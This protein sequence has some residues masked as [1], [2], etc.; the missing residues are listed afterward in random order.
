M[1]NSTIEIFGIRHH[2]PGSARSLRRALE[3]FK[4]DMILVEGPPDADA[5][6]AQAAHH[7]MQP[8]VALLVYNPK[9]LEQASFF[10][11][12]EF[13]PEWQAIRYGQKSRVSV[14]FMD[15]PM[16]QAF[17]L[18]EPE[19]QLRLELTPLAKEDPEIDPFRKI[20]R[21]A[22]YT[23]PERWW[24][25]MVE[26]QSGADI[27]PAILDL[28]M[29]LR[30]DK[31]RPETRETLLREAFMRQ[32][33]RGALQEGYARIAVVCGAWHTP[34]LENWQTIKASADAALLK[35][36][37]KI[38][39]ETTW[40]PWSF[41]RLAAQN[42]YSAGV[43]APAWYRVL[44]GSVSGNPAPAEPS[45]SS[46]GHLYNP[47]VQWLTKVAHLLRESDMA[48]SPAHIIEAVRL[49]ETLAVLR[50]T[51]LPG[52]EELREAAVT[53]LCD[54]AEKPLELI[55]RQLVIG[56]VLGRVPDSLPV[57]PLKADFE[58]QV[59]SCRLEKN[60]QEK[61][62]E[63]D[64]RQDAHLRKS[65]LLHRLDLLGIQWGTVKDAVSG[66]QGG[67]HEHWQLKWLPDYEIRLIE[68]GTWGNTVED[69]AGRKAHR[70]VLESQE[71]AGLVRLL[72][73]LLKANL[74]AALPVLLQKLQQIT[75]LARDALLLADAVLPL[76]GVLRYGTARRLN[77]DAVEQLLEQIIPR[78]CIQLPAACSGVNGD[79]AEDILKK[80]LSVNRALGIL[81]VAEYETGWQNTLS[82]IGD[83]D[84]TAPLLSGLSTR[85]LF[86]KN[87]RTAALTGDRMRYHLSHAS[88]PAEAAQWL[89]GFL[90]GSGL[91]LLLHAELWSTVDGW[92][93][94]QGEETFTEL[95]P[96]LRRAFSRF[97]APERQKMLD[98]AKQATHPSAAS[99]Q[100]N[101]WDS[102]RAAAVLE[103]VK[104][105]FQE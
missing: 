82:V 8:P 41:D 91:L 15:L 70:R 64:L 96:L 12:A 53:V 51:S 68:A 27:F 35:G 44:W 99:G 84:N 2:G 55:D 67:F 97:S 19:A 103:L 17:Q 29:A 42:G 1:T 76:A 20:A 31:S 90:Y 102:R 86:D 3:E 13:S 7:E 5:L 104:G 73:L 39:T 52:I 69:A 9:N 85:L 40:I 65:L 72:G 22:G 59:K 6:I 36:L 80:I 56:D 62:L 95:L 48:V 49:A 54:G 93:K 45:E 14:R 61:T 78:V 28:M 75:A 89:E 60:T 58:A 10:P 94:E 33:I 83:G 43:V 100:K 47:V 79:V 66:K 81:Q 11:F 63:L 30:N 23:D 37:K 71:L 21:L 18:K 25:A 74:P 57:P 77:L 4:P 26:R 34:A 38:K 92:V 88:A 101:D 50:R 32:T 46:S 105:I 16:S 24:D 98:L 87:I